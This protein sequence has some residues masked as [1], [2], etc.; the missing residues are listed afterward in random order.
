MR[1]L[2]LLLALLLASCGDLPRP[3]QGSPGATARRLAV[4][5]PPR[6]AVPAPTE[7]LLSDAASRAFAEAVA[8]NLRGAEVPAVA[9]RVR[10]GD[11]R[12]VMAAEQRAGTVVPTYTVQNPKGEPQGQAEGKPIPAKAWAAAT[13]DTLLAAAADAGPPVSQLLTRIEAAIQQSD[14]NSL[15]NRPARVQVADVTGAPGDG[16]ASLAQQVKNHLSQLGPVVQDS[17]KGAD[18]V[19][20]RQVR[21]VPIAGKRVRVEIQWI[22]KDAT[23]A[24]RGRV[25]QLN[26]VP[27]GTLD[28]YW[29]DVAVAVAKEA[30][31]GLKDVILTQSGRR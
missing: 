3:F 21:V 7:A 30:S 28:G 9:E 26:E 19:V 23:A 27:A 11:W 4:P 1:F 8:N 15:Y 13:P 24:E 5:P 12:L 6:L 10:P 18:F 31:A 25:V 29:G 16:N 14:P 20:A 2:S 17:G 22:V